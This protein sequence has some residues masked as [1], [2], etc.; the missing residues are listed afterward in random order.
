MQ[1]CPALLVLVRHAESERNQGKKGIFFSDDQEREKL[2]ATS[3]HRMGLTP[4][5]ERQARATG[6]ELRSRF[7]RFDAVYHSGHE[8][9]V[10][11]TRGLLEAWPEAER[12]L[13]PVDHDVFLRE[14]DTGYA[15]DMTRA[16]AEA[17]FPW[18]DGYWRT[19]GPFFARPPGGESVA[20]VCGRTVMVL[21]HLARQHAG[22]RVLLVTHGQVIRTFR[23]LIE[24]WTHAEM[25]AN[26]AGPPPRNAGFTVYEPGDGAL[27]LQV[28]DQVV[29][30][31]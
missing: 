1:P 5:G 6:V 26:L 4:L 31:G 19:T 17:A 2:R 10:A 23:Y 13:M 30:P 7:G 25:E 21:D 8:R 28:Y 9:T 11:T 14:R 18:L 29:D 20:D 3:D 16:E 27:R 24:G 12:A 22:Q 15:W